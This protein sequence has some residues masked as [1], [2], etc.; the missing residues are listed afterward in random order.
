MWAEG[1]P[2]LLRYIHDGRVSRVLPVSVVS[3][4]ERSTQLFVR[5]GTPMRTRCGPD[6]V[7]LPRSLPYAERFARPWRLGPSVWS[8]YHVLMLTPRDAGHSFWA[9]WDDGWR[10]HGWYV[11]LQEPLRRSRFGFD[12]ADNVLDLVVRPDLS[13]QWKDED[14]LH[15]AVRLGRFTASEADGL[16]EE[17]ARATAAIDA[18]AWPFDRDWSGWRPAPAWPE[19]AL[20]AEADEP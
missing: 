12:T 18:R 3:D 15:E 6:G 1:D 4:D 9:Y 13:W 7:P 17:G 16:Y 5:S 10:F 20:V 2:A 19:P 8:G 11:N 14:E